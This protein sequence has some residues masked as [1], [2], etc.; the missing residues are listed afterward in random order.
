M[1]I[2]MTVIVHE[3]ATDGLPDMDALTGE[4]VFIFDGCIVSGWPLLRSKFARSSYDRT[5]GPYA[6]YDGTDTLWEGNTDVAHVRPFGGVT[7]WIE[8]PVPG[9]AIPAAYGA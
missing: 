7:H 9:H 1:P 8:L 2:P 4:V 5:H 6:G 3:I